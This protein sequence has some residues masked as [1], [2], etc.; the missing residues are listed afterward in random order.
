[1]DVDMDNLLTNFD[2]SPLYI[3]YPI[4]ALYGT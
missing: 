1:M 3:L 2:P 4:K